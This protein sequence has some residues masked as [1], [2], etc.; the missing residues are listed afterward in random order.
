M[1]VC[2][3]L[4]ILSVCSLSLTRTSSHFPSQPPVTLPSFLY[5]RDTIYPR[6]GPITPLD[7]CPTLPSLIPSPYTEHSFPVSPPL[8]SSHHHVSQRFIPR[9]LASPEA[10]HKGVGVMPGISHHLFHLLVRP[11]SPPPPPLLPFP[12]PPPQ[13]RCGTC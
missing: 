13:Q 6:G 4:S 7:Q 5:T 12:V 2:V 10:F 11:C 9:G 8:L 1:C 3:C